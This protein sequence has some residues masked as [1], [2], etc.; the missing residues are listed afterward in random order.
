M[1]TD[2]IIKKKKAKSSEKEARSSSSEKK[3]NNT[4]IKFCRV[5]KL[6]VLC[7]HP[8][9]GDNLVITKSDNPYVIE[10]EPVSQQKKT[11]LK[12]KTIKE[13][14]RE[15]EKIGVFDPRAHITGVVGNKSSQ[16]SSKDRNFLRPMPYNEKLRLGGKENSLAIAETQLSTLEVLRGRYRKVR[17]GSINLSSPY[18]PNNR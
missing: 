1:L 3:H 13:L 15:K 4:G 14:E 8:V 18:N 12:L 9:R 7:H 17:R 2:V 6:K 11:K 5:Q 16:G 10:V